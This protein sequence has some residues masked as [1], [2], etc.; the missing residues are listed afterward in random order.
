VLDQFRAAMNETRQTDPTHGIVLTDD[1]NPVDFHDA[2]NR[3]RQR[4]ELA[5]S[6]QEL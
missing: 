6:M 1:F 2:Q 4:R 3:E 5:Q